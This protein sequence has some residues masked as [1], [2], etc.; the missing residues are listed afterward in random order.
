MPGYTEKV[1]LSQYEETQRVKMEEKILHKKTVCLANSQLRLL[2][3]PSVAGTVT[4]EL[5][6]TVTTDAVE[7]VQFYGLSRLTDANE[8]LIQT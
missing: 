8:C 4:P 5:V 7:C 6:F 1:G 2:Y 3:V